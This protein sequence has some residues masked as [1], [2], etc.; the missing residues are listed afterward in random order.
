VLLFLILGAKLRFFLFFSGVFFFNEKLAV[1]GKKV[2]SPQTVV[3]RKEGQKS[4]KIRQKSASRLIINGKF[5]V[6]Y[7]E[8]RVFY[9]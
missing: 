8:I 1:K 2:I 7:M 6:N 5:V 3:R 4:S 9:L